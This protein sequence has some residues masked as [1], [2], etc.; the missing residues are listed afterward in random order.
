MGRGPGSFMDDDTGE[1]DWDSY[2]DYKRD[3]A[4][5][6]AAEQHYA[7]RENHP[8]RQVGK[9]RF[10]ASQAPEGST[11]N[12]TNPDGSVTTYPKSR[13]AFAPGGEGRKREWD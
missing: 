7:R 12:V 2:Y 13:A 10:T 3:V 5:D 8:N 1:P 9:E 11:T 4:K 6:E